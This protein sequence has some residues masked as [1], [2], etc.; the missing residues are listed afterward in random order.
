MSAF[1][2]SFFSWCDQFFFIENAKMFEQTSEFMALDTL[3]Y[4]CTCSK[5]SREVVFLYIVLRVHV[6]LQKI[7]Y[8]LRYKIYK[9]FFIISNITHMRNV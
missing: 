9:I 3:L 8:K 5:A 1:C 4:N 7:S 6:R 2:F